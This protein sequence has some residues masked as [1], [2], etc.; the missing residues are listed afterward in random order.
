MTQAHPLT[1]MTRF[2]LFWE[3]ADAVR[4]R[5]NLPPLDYE[6]ARRWFDCEVEPD[7]VPAVLGVKP[8]VEKMTRKPHPLRKWRKSRSI[9]QVT[10]AKE[11]GV[12][13]SHLCQIERRTRLPSLSLCARLAAH[14]GI[15]LIEF[16]PPDKAV[17]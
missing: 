3:A 15:P 16:L 9:S 12:V 5:R 4:V 8:A 14:T 1:T 17:P 2:R 11:I 7:D 10:L 6:Q 13:P